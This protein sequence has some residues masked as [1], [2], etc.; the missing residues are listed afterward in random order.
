[1]THNLGQSHLLQRLSERSVACG[2]ELNSSSVLLLLHII[3][4]D[5]VSVNAAEACKSGVGKIF[6]RFSVSVKCGFDS[7][8]MRV[9]SK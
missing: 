5:H 1:M 4:F 2:R 9:K 6:S 8:K 7:R 3:V